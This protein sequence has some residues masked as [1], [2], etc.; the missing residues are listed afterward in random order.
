MNV[1]LF[2]MQ[3]LEHVVSR[4]RQQ[5]TKRTK[6]KN[7]NN[8]EILFNI[9]IAC[10]SYVSIDILYIFCNVCIKKTQMKNV[11]IIIIITLYIYDYD[12]DYK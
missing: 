2:K 6:T 7:N 3:L 8:K 10:V 9:E 1:S 12:Y 11:F 5:K 4:K